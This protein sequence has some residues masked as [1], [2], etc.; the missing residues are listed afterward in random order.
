M[1][2]TGMNLLRNSLKMCLE[3]HNYLYD[4]MIR[5]V[6]PEVKYP[7][8]TFSAA[9]KRHG[10]KKKKLQAIIKALRQRR[11][12]FQFCLLVCT[13]AVGVSLYNI[14]GLA[15]I[16][17]V[18]AWLSSFLFLL[19]NT[20][21]LWQCENKKLGSVDDFLADGGFSLMLQ[22]GRGTAAAVSIVALVFICS[23]S[24]SA[25]ADND[26]GM[27]LYA[28]AAD[29]DPSLT[30]LAK[31]VGGVAGVFP[32]EDT[33][34][35][36]TFLV[37]NTAVLAVSLLFLLWNFGAGVVQTAHEGEFLG[38]RFSSIWMPIRNVVGVGGLVPVFGGWSACQIV[39]LWATTIG[40]GLA[41]LVWQTGYAVV[42]EKINT[43]I[44][45]PQAAINDNAIKSIVKAQVCMIMF[46]RELDNG[47]SPGFGA[48]Q[49]TKLFEN[50]PRFKQHGPE[51]TTVVTRNLQR[52]GKAATAVKTAT[53]VRMSWG[54]QGEGDYPVDL[55][56]GV[57]VSPESV[58]TAERSVKGS[59]Q[60]FS[61]S[62]A[63]RPV[64][65]RQVIINT[66]KVAL[67]KMAKSL[68]PVS[69]GIANGKLP[70]PQVFVD[71]KTQYFEDLGVAIAAEVMKANTQFAE[72]MK[73]DGKSWINAGTIFQKIAAVNTEIQ[74]ALTVQIDPIPTPKLDEAVL[75]VIHTYSG[76]QEGI[77]LYELWLDKYAKSG[78]SGGNADG[79]DE[80]G[81][82]SVKNPDLNLLVKP[83]HSMIV[84]KTLHYMT[85]G[86]TN[87][88]SGLMT[89][90]NIMLSAAPV[91]LGG[92]VVLV[93]AGQM[94]TGAKGLG[95]GPGNPTAAW[96]LVASV[97]KYIFLFFILMGLLL[98]VYLPFLP[99]VIWYGGVL[100]WAICVLE[101][102]IAAPLWMFTHMEADGE[103][104]GNKSAHG[105]LFILNVL[106]RPALMI[107]ALIAA[108]L[109]LE[110][111]G[112]FLR[113]SLSVLFGSS[114]GQFSGLASLF[115]FFG[116]LFIFVSLAIT[117]VNK[118]FGL[119]DILPNQVFAW[120]GGH[121]NGVG[122]SEAD[123]ESKQMFV[124]GVSNQRGMAQGKLRGGPK[125]P[126]VPSG[127]GI[128][129]RNSSM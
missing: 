4:K 13:V 63:A 20:L 105:Y 125:P 102:V 72:Y 25:M 17:S 50:D 43:P 87:L 120:V 94:F 129:P 12:L 69:T 3:F 93:A 38:K 86:E 66:T 33:A 127:D 75:R 85:L 14:R 58:S 88:F 65:D 107:M 113:E 44:V 78:G 74:G 36:A 109:M 91:A 37:F 117:T 45:T 76:A 64:V 62:D 11:V 110:V 70:N 119:I 82:F 21:R 18:L 40:V 27:G 67:E 52:G 34:L 115:T 19:Q 104:M 5:G 22:I 124:G 83:F 128:T 116:V 15:L 23:L 48:G 99:L 49:D 31:I 118:L 96:G 30:M 81:K 7:D 111:F 126:V 9:C 29:G 92:S 103:G 55:C 61:I 53:G 2:V 10:V 114:A 95:T 79:L 101:A 121:Y 32:G 1:F 39:M 73:T 47:S 89:T 123:R 24:T 60:H 6:R 106:F 71:I 42:L 51:L 35:T 8:D 84:E 54:G 80:S 100:V 59:S 16:M 68:L 41:N 90:G 28:K 26:T 122:G 57:V 56:G 108:W 98:A 112:V 46:N 97:V 77:R